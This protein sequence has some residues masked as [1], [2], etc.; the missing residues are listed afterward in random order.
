M[1]R[2]YFIGNSL[3]DTVNYK[4]LDNLAESQQKNHIWGRHMIPG[5]PLSWLWQHPNDGFR[6]DPFGYPTTALTQYE[7]DA[8]SLQPFDRPIEGE[9]GD[10]AMA[11]NFINL[12]KAKSPNLQVYIYQHWV[13]ADRGA[14][15]RTL[16]AEEWNN[17]WLAEYK[18]G[19][20][21]NNAKSYY[22]LLVQELRK[23]HPDLPP[24]QLVR[25]GEVLHALNIRMQRGEV[26]GYS[27]VWQLYTDAVHLNNIGEYLVGATYYSTL[28]R[29]SPQN[30]IIPGNY[31]TIPSSIAQVIQQTVWDVVSR[32]RPLGESTV[33]LPALPSNPTVFLTDTTVIEGQD[34]T[35][36]ITVSLS[37][38][39]SQTLTI[40][41][42][43]ADGTAT[44]GND[45]TATSGTLT[46]A[47]GQTRQT[48]AIPILSDS[49][50]ETNETFTV[51]FSTSQSDGLILSDKPVTVT[52]GEMIQ[53][54]I[55]VTLPDGILN[56]MLIGNEAINGTGNSGNNIIIGNS[57][58]NLL[59]GKAGYDRLQGG[60]G[61][62]TYR[63]ESTF[64]DL[65]IENK[66]AGTD[67][68]QSAG[69]FV[70]QE[71]IEN[72]VLIG[73]EDANAT[74]NALD[75]KL[76]GNPANNVLDGGAGNDQMEGKA[77]NDTY[78]VDSRLDTIVEQTDQG[79]DSVQAIVSHTLAANIENLFLSG[80]G[81]I[82]GG[83]NQLDN[84]IVGNSG[85]NQI[86]GGIG[87][88]TLMGMGGSDRITGNQGADRFVYATATPDSRVGMLD[89]LTD[90]NAKQGDRIQLDFDNNLET[91]DR[92][93]GIFNLGQIR[94][95][96]NLSRVLRVAYGDKNK[97]AKGKQSLQVGEAISLGWRGKTYLS[98]NGGSAKF[99]VDEDWVIELA[100]DRFV[101]TG[102]LSVNQY[103]A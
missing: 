22:D 92:P 1:T 79:V 87:K 8:L 45:Y 51:K 38:A 69:S 50:L 66:D 81:S 30:T 16:T 99:G 33:T 36:Q 71:N 75:N 68:V 9:E 93:N 78:V 67:E 13:F 19:Y 88:D 90:F 84:K 56:L 26:P 46:F 59:D 95:G 23:D 57:A 24:V 35:A 20:S 62:D 52:I 21:N 43:T 86:V 4:G 6:E 3:T 63:V 94:P 102:R 47:P 98:V 44:A 89:R 48:I 70:L 64:W 28:Y 37:K 80:A 7:W 100:G 42:A 53:S 97:R 61:D 72:L 76:T 34:K 82:N 11:N 27:S 55:S 65:V 83:G 17:K 25:V 32:D 49:N 96:A 39:S 77:G 74:G 15:L 12:A 101:G 31:G 10:L 41:Y 5:A 60:L 85:Q 73:N 29:A 103:F 2:I 40:A 18:G 91:S 58:S 54:S 14:D